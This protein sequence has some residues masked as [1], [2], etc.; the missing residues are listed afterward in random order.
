M[1]EVARFECALFEGEH[2][3]V[4]EKQCDIAQPMLA[5]PP[6]RSAK[7][8]LRN[9]HRNHPPLLADRG[10]ERQGQGAG[11]ATDFEHALAAGEAQARQQ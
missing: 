5:D 2:L 7:H 3:R 4:P 11:A 6:P 9:V 1:R 10:G 8:R